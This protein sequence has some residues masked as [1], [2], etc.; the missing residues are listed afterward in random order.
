[1]EKTLIRLENLSKYYTSGQNV[2]VGLNSLNLQFDRGEFVAITGESGSG[3]STL[4][5]VISGIMPYEGGE[6]YFDGKP[7]SH[8]DGQ[9]WEQYRRDSIS[10]ISQSYDILPGATVLSNVITALRLTGMEKQ[11]AMTGAEKI[12]HQVDLWSLR[13][14]RAAKLSS[15]QKQRLSIAR[16]LAKPAPILIADEPT[17]NLDPENSKKIIELLSEAAKTR[18]VLLVTHEFS[19]AENHATRH[20]VLQDGRIVMDAALRPANKPGEVSRPR[21]AKKSAL[22]LFVSLLQ[23]KSRPIWSCLMV[24]LASLTAFSVFAFLGTF[25]IALD[26]TDT[27]IYDSSA[28]A[29]GS[30]TRIVVSTAEQRPLTEEDFKNILN[31]PYVLSLETNGYVTDMQYAYRDGIDY[32]TTFS[33]EVNEMTGAS[34]ITSAYMPLPTAPFMKTVPLLPSGELPLLDGRLPDSFYE[35]V[36]NKEDGYAVGDTVTVLFTNKAFWGAYQFAE[37]KFTVVGITDYGEGLYFDRS[38]GRFAQQIQKISNKTSEFFVFVPE[39]LASTA[40]QIEELRKDGHLL[41]NQDLYL[42]DYQ[43]RCHPN[44]FARWAGSVQADW[45]VQIKFPDINADMPLASSNMYRLSTPQNITSP[46]DPAKTIQNQF[47]NFR[48]TRLIE[49]SQNTFDK[50]TWNTASEQV[51][52]TIKDYAFTDRVLDAL[53]EK[54]YIAISPYQ[55]GSTRINQAK[56]QERMQTLSVCLAAVAAVAALQILL[57]RAM[58]SVQ[59]ESYRLLKNIG[60]VSKTAKRSLLW[61]IL[62][63]TLLGQ[64][65]GGIAIWLCDR[66]GVQRITD[67]MKYLPTKY[68]AVLCIVHILLSLIAAYWTV[69]AL[70]KHVYPL[71]KHHDDINLDVEEQEVNA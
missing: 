51:S 63:F 23:Q 70:G 20:I 61:Q 59:T 25:I 34:S 60:L 8:Y 1:M 18:L 67:M 39:D 66:L 54:G 36:A 17:G 6:L 43:F 30:H 15:G 53:R 2:V 27:R 4:S 3:K 12:L 71:V 13:H 55:T 41:E 7:T 38:L 69:S 24:L 29:N 47:H 37:M 57:L 32:K 10:F 22:S 49:V 28:F 65:L 21:P 50:L 16:A 26:D 5:H 42:K 33:E 19:E 48:H 35:V 56:A 44:Q 52:L 14:R 40:K 64:V 46:I 45:S 31:T 9:N 62:S 68:V 11:D 58:F